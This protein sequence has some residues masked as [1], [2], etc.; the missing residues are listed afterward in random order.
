MRV[1][2]FFAAAALVAAAVLF[3]A[4]RS[5]TITAPSTATITL[6]AYPATIPAGSGMATIEVKVIDGT[7]PA[8]EGTI[9]RLRTDKGT[10]EN[11]RVE[12]DDEGLAETRLQAPATPG[13]ATIVGSSGA[14]DDAEVQV[15]I[16]SA[17]AGSKDR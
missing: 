3:A 15:T 7:G 12:T 10:L 14:A 16:T 9:V 13:T 4:C 17:G 2:H 6:K 11:D 5:E 8:R 1:S